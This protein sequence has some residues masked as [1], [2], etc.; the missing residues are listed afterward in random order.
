MGWRCFLIILGL[1]GVA[2]AGGRQAL[3]SENP[4]GPHPGYISDVVK[5][6]NQRDMEIVLVG[7]PKPTHPPLKQQIFNKKL[8]KEFQDEY[9]YRFGKTSIEQTI[10]SPGRNDEYQYYT[11][12][13][14]N[15]QEYQKYQRDFGEYMGRRLVE[16]H[17]DN[18]AK[19]DPSFKAVYEAKQRLS[20][21]NVKV[22]NGYQMKWKYNFAGNYMDVKLENPYKIEAKIDLYMGGGSL[23]DEQ[24]YT[25]GVPVTRTWTVSSYYKTYDGL[26]QL[27]GS[28][29]LGPHM[30]ATITGSTDS[31]DRGP[32]VKQ[33]LFLVG[34]SWND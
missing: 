2:V 27:V 8:S 28:K 26:F 29:R 19:S 12:E 20:N 34:L 21:L 15:I 32:T 1:F 22:K 24:T 6:R 18:W 9:E 11:G 14:V 25:L 31:S 7:R 10:N 4:L 3:A 13:T 5:E 17:V 33:D 30:S 16:Y 23:F